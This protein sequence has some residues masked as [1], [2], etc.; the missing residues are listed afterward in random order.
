MVV[1]VVAPDPGKGQLTGATGRGMDSA[2]PIQ[3]SPVAIFRTDIGCNA[4]AGPA[5]AARHGHQQNIY[6][7]A[8]L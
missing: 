3:P 1:G 8:I 5:T 6:S 7:A 4:T 2:K